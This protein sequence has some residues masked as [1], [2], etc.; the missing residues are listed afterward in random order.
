M[1]VAVEINQQSD[2]VGLDS[3]LEG[4]L[5]GGVVGVPNREGVQVSGGAFLGFSVAINLAA[6]EAAEDEVGGLAG[7]FLE[8]EGGGLSE[9]AGVGIKGE[10]S[11]GAIGHM[12]GFFASAM[13]SGKHHGQGA[14]DN[15]DVRGGWG[16]GAWGR[17]GGGGAGGWERGVSGKDAQGDGLGLRR[18]GQRRRPVELERGINGVGGAS[19]LDAQQKGAGRR[20]RVQLEEEVGLRVLRGEA[21]GV[22]V[23]EDSEGLGSAGVALIPPEQGGFDAGFGNPQMDAQGLWACGGFGGAQYNPNLAL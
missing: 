2:A 13:G 21:R 20:F 12:L 17:R 22:A 18:C 5:E 9:F 10:S 11:A 14:L 1:T 7:G 19:G 3:A 8:G 15:L 6:V 23:R 16:G 4:G